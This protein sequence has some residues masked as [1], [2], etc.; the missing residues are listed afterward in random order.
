MKV[1]PVKCRPLSRVKVR[2]IAQRGYLL[3]VTVRSVILPTSNTRMN[4]LEQGN[5]FSD[6]AE[7]TKSLMEDKLNW[8]DVDSYDEL[9]HK[10][11]QLIHNDTSSQEKMRSLVEDHNNEALVKDPSQAVKYREE[12][13]KYFQRQKYSEA[14]EFYNQAVLISP[15]PETF[16]QQSDFQDFAL[17]L[18]NRFESD[19]PLTLFFFCTEQ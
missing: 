9:F 14:L 3:L 11:Y 2:G 4:P 1:H 8:R 10:A 5:P 13:N 12:G 6:I 7:I 17:S 19:F 18:T 16:K 15:S